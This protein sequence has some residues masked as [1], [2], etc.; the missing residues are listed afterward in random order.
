VVWPDGSVRWPGRPRAVVCDAMEKPWRMVG[1]N[2]DITERKQAEALL[3]QNEGL[4]VA[5]VEQAP[6]GVYVVD[7]QFGCNRSTPRPAVFAKVEPITAG[8]LPR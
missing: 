6:T 4:F 7:A 1:V 8:I 2:T 3:R 5:L